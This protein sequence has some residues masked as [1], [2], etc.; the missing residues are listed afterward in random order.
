RGTVMAAFCAGADMATVCGVSELRSLPA[1]DPGPGEGR[2]P[3]VQRRS[4]CKMGARLR[5]NLSFLFYLALRDQAEALRFD[6][7]RRVEL[8]AEVFE[9][10]RRRQF[11]DL[12]LVVMP[13]ELLEQCVIDLLAG[14]CHALGIVE[15]TTLGLAEQ[16]AV[17][18]TR[19]RR[20]PFVAAILPHTEG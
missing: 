1:K 13:L 20:Q 17:A 4:G 9:R 2:D 6:A 3:S 15:R 19:Y 16:R 10:N 8:A 7:E 18:P 14:D 12:S 11:D 5:P